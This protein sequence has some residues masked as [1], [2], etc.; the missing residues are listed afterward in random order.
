MTTFY[1]IDPNGNFEHIDALDTGKGYYECHGIRI[2]EHTWKPSK[3]IAWR[4]YR[5]VMI[6]KSQACVKQMGVYMKEVDKAQEEINA[7]S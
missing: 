4:D 1:S 6:T 7:L 2:C 5:D 3:W